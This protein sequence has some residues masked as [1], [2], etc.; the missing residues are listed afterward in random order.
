MTVDVDN[1]L[2][3][4]VKQYGCGMKLDPS[5]FHDWSIWVATGLAA[6]ATWIGRVVF[7]NNR[8]IDALEADHKHARELR[9]RQ[10]AVIQEIR[11][12]QKTLLSHLLKSR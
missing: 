12:D 4:T 3:L 2:T 11:A 8:R 5:I 7:T 9:E 6:F 1:C 10:D